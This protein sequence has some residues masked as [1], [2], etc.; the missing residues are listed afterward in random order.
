MIVA[1]KQTSEVTRAPCGCEFWT[2]EFDGR[3]RFVFRPHAM[4]CPKYL[5]AMEESKKHGKNVTLVE[6]RRVGG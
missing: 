4:D 1:P 5:Y 6:S 3:A 2:D